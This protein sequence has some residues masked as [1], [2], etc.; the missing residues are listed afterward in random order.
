MPEL[1]LTFDRP[2]AELQATGLEA[3]AKQATRILHN[4]ILPSW[5]LIHSLSSARIDIV[6]D[7]SGFELFTDLLLADYLVS[8]TPHVSKVVFHGKGI[9]WFVSDVVPA[10]FTRLVSSLADPSF[11]PT[12][13]NAQSVESLEAL[14]T[15]AARWQ[16]HIETGRFTM[17]V[18]MGSRLGEGGAADFWCGPRTFHHLPAEAPELLVEMQKAKLVIFKG[19]VSSF[20]STTDEV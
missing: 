16:S 18:P 20:L 4:D 5:N 12:S 11:F 7:N 8:C 9:P 1:A 17:S 14:A 15:M 6:L 19:D 10:D 3:Q 13:S 2:A